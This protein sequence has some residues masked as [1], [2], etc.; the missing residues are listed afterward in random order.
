MAKKPISIRYKII[1]ALLLPI[2]LLGIGVLATGWLTYTPSLAKEIL[3]KGLSNSHYLAIRSVNLML[4]REYP[5]ITNLAIEEQSFD[6][7]IAYIFFLDEKRRVVAHTFHGDFPVELS[8]AN[9]V[10]PE[11][12]E[13]YNLLFCLDDYFYDLAVPIHTEGTRIGELRMGI[14][15]S[16]IDQPLQKF[17]TILSLSVVAIA[18]LGTAFSII[19]ANRMIRPLRK[20]TRRAERLGTRDLDSPIEIETGDE[21]EQLAQAFN[22][23]GE[24]LKSAYTEL[25][26]KVADRTRELEARNWELSEMNTA[27]R[28]T[29][30][31]IVFTLEDLDESN[32]KL[33]EMTRSLQEKTQEME[34]FLYSVSHDL[35]APVV[36][37]NGFS[38][39][40]LDDFSSILGGEGKH[41]LERIKVNTKQMEKLIDDLLI[42]SRIGRVPLNLEVVVLSDLVGDVLSELHTLLE[43]SKGQVRVSSELP[44][45]RCDRKE[46]HRVLLNLI[47]N[48]NKYAAEGT[49][50]DIKVGCDEDER[51][52]RIYV[53]DN[54]PGIDV[55]NHDKI[56]RVFQQLGGNKQ[57]GTGV[58]LAI[59]KKAVEMHRGTVWVESDPGR[60][61]TFFFTLPKAEAE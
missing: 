35:R 47:E 5:K 51:F 49:P 40:L 60:G 33:R 61:S 48:A 52:Y 7:S 57:G 39:I 42:L 44:T 11:D 58:G 41:F 16:Y 26:R 20:L 53:S 19:M 56:F 50:P 22:Q 28:R 38:N 25:E 12:F 32:E 9:W 59:V 37:I 43:V 54:G 23:M 15:K 8:D 34:E 31:A 10:L 46:I 27:L 55:R 36:S 17:M 6:H 3:R 1:S 14:H 24:R 30:S 45:V 13:R 21:I 2:V 29:Q 4:A 18:T